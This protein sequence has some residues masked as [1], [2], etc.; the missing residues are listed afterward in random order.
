MNYRDMMMEFQDK[1]GK[2]VILRFI[3]IGSPRIVYNQHMEA[4]FRH[5]DVA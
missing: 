5:E 2:K 3:S 1:G 4:L